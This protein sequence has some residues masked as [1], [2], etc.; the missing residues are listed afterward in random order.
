MASPPSA[1]PPASGFTFDDSLWPLLIIHF[2]G[3]PTRAELE[4]YLAKRLEYMQRNEPHVL[5]Y[6]TRHARMLNNELIQ[7]HVAW[8]RE[9]DVLR[10]KTVMASVVV[11]TSPVIRLTASAILHFWPPKTPYHFGSNLPEAVRWA[12]DWLQKAGHHAQANL[13]RQRYASHPSR[14]PGS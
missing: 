8:M 9:H 12:A 5:L 2:L 4:T 1:K 11:I 10:R 3:N 13:V 6:D 7:R 14:P